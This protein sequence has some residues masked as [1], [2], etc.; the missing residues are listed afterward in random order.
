VGCAVGPKL[1]RVAF[2]KQ[3]NNRKKVQFGIMKITIRKFSLSIIL[4]VVIIFILF[5]I[6]IPPRI[7]VKEIISPDH[8]EIAY[9]SWK[10]AG[11][12]GYITK[13]NTWVYLEVKDI[14][15]EK[16]VLNRFAWGDYP[17]DGLKRFSHERPWF[18]IH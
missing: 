5:I 1:G 16:I 17:E 8:S 14:K 9:F 11:I 3:D 2:L 12:F 4:C 15:T 10:P 7:L 18:L 6:P 13:D